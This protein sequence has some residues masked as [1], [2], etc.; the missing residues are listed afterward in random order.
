MTIPGRNV[1]FGA[2]TRKIMALSAFIFHEV[3]SLMKTDHWTQ[4]TSG[5]VYPHF[6]GS[7]SVETQTWGVLFQKYLDNRR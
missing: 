6:I 5:I 7:W 2:W 3:S 4:N 1:I